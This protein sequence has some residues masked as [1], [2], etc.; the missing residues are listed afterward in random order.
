MRPTVMITVSGDTATT[1]LEAGTDVALTDLVPAWAR[2][3]SSERPEDL[4]VVSAGDTMWLDRGATL[5]EVG[6]GEG[7]ALRLLTADQ[8]RR[9]RRPRPGEAVRSVP[10]DPPPARLG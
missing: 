3:C 1:D 4:I 8:A 2:R 9:A 7:S 10:E 6:L 5:A